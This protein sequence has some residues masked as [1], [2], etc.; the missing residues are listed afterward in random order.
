MAEACLTSATETKFRQCSV[1]LARDKARHHSHAGVIK[2]PKAL[3]M[4]NV[5]PEPKFGSERHRR[6]E[7]WNIKPTI[8]QTAAFANVAPPLASLP[9]QTYQCLLPLTSRP[10]RD[11]IYTSSSFWRSILSLLP[12]ILPFRLRSGTLALP[13][14]FVIYPSI[15]TRFGTRPDSAQALFVPYFTILEP[16]ERPAARFRI[17]GTSELL[18]LGRS[19][20]PSGSTAAPDLPLLFD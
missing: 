17:H 3:Q 4:P 18:P 12:Q 15:S 10:R 13:L 6:R 1:Q 5:A 19:G 14:T 9:C 7:H 11:I 16:W 8:S 20:A 2:Y